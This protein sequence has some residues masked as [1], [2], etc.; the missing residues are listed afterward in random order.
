[1]GLLGLKAFDGV[2]LATLFR[3]GLAFFLCYNS[4]NLFFGLGILRVVG[5]VLVEL[6]IGL[7]GD[8]GFA[9]ILYFDVCLGTRGLEIDLLD[10]YIVSGLET[11][12]LEAD[13]GTSLALVLEGNLV[14]FDTVVNEGLFAL[15]G[16]WPNEELILNLIEN[17]LEFFCKGGL[18]TDLDFC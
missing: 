13:L 14:T 1:M 2:T 15:L 6:E 5:F 18:E 10:M 11:A 9:L 4:I 17:L 3:L 7:F 12:G 8:I 16:S